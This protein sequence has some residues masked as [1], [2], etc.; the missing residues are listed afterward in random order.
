M[1]IDKA[2]KIAQKEIETDI[3]NIAVAKIK[4]KMIELNAAKEGVREIEAELTALK[5]TLVEDLKYVA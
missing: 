1:D 5:T 2:L 4:A 3:I